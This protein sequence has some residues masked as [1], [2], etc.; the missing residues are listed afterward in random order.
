MSKIRYFDTFNK[1]TK[2]YKGTVIWAQA[3]PCKPWGFETIYQEVI[4]RKYPIYKESEPELE[5][6]W[7]LVTIDGGRAPNLR[8]KVGEQSWVRIPHSDT[9]EYVCPWDPG[10]YKLVAKL[11]D[12]EWTLQEEKDNE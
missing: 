1:E 5:D 6:G 3:A 2:A 9:E 7:Y 8:H 4:D 11:N 12:I 10:R